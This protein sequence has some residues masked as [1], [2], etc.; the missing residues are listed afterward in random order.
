MANLEERMQAAEETLQITGHVF[1]GIRNRFI[2]NYKR[3]VLAD[4][5]IELQGNI[6]YG[7]K[8]AH[9]SDVIADS[10]FYKLHKRTDMDVFYSLYQVSVE[11]VLMLGKPFPPPTGRID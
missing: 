9:E 11:I 8:I 2:D 6:D 10:L 4:P 1:Y 3:K 5:D 7:N